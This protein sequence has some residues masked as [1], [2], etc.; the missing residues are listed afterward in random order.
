MAAI[1]DQCCIDLEL[2]NDKFFN[3]LLSWGLFE[4]VNIKLDTDYQPITELLRVS[5]VNTV[6]VPAN[7]VAV[8]KIG[9]PVGQYI[10]VLSIC[11]ELSAQERLPNQPQFSASAPPGTLPNGVDIGNYGGL[12]SFSNF[13]G[14]TLWGA[15]GGLP[16]RGHYKM[17]RRQNGEFEILLD[18]GLSMQQV[19]VEGIALGVNANGSTICHPYL[20]DFVR[21]AVHH[22]YQ[23]FLRGPEKLLSEIERTGREM[24]DAEMKVRGRTSNLDRATL[25]T[26][27]RKNYR[28]TPAI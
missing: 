17:V 1:V 27:M 10:S 24:W 5:D 26:I 21:K 19:Y 9:I 11:E 7:W 25:L 23:K 14:R 4:Y 8:T 22:N 12:Y 20:A 6:R 13:C 15:S 18:A 16:K 3:K 2:P 28:L